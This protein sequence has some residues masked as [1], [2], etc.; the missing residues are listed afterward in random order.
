MQG[1]PELFGTE[2]QEAVERKA[3]EEGIPMR[4]EGR[5]RDVFVSEYV[6]EPF[7]LH[8]VTNEPVWFNHAQVFHWT[9]FPAELFAAFHRTRQPR[10]LLHAL[11]VSTVSLIKYGLLRKK[12]AL[13]VSFGDGTP[14]SVREM[15]QIRKAIHKNMVFNRWQEGDL[16]MI[17]NFSTSHGRQ[18]TYDKGRKVVVAW[19]DPIRKSNLAKNENMSHSLSAW[20]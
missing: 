12:M 19:S 3:R 11:R 15:H 16:L 1:W 18:P 20:Q 14:I 2:D 6:D 9:T 8:P 5:N 10:M 17:D 4:W 7:Q 13:D